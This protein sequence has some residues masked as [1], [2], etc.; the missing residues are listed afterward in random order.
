MTGPTLSVIAS[1]QPLQKS[2]SWAGDHD[3]DCSIVDALH[4]RGAA[5]PA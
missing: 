1:Y 3:R 2:P 5:A 4:H